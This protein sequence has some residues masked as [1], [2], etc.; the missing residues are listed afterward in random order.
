MKV[1]LQMNNKKIS[2]QTKN[3]MNSGFFFEEHHREIKIPR[4]KWEKVI[5]MNIINKGLISK[6]NC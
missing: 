3:L 6:N 2:Q 5:E 1:I 4:I